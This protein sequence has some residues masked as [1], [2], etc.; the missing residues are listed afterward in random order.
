MFHTYST[1]ARGID[2]LNGTYHFL[3]LT[4]KGR[5]EGRRPGRAG[6]AI[7]T[8]TGRPAREAPDATVEGLGRR[9]TPQLH[10]NLGRDGERAQA[11]ARRLGPR[12]PGPDL[13]ALGRAPVADRE[14]VLDPERLLPHPRD[15]GPHRHGIPVSDRRDEPRPR[16]EDG[17]ADDAVAR[18][19]LGPREAERGEERLGPECP[20]T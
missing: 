6:C 10:D 5:D 19:G 11:R 20:T 18:E 8:N 7:T 4:P 13:E 1:Y 12:D 9:P 17:H 15:P 3:D 14:V 16:L 2:M